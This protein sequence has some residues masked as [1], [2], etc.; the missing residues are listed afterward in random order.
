M[1]RIKQDQRTIRSSQ[2]IYR[3]LAQLMREKSFAKISVTNIVE[4]AQ[5]G[6]TTFYRIFD[7]I[8]DV[9]NLRMWLEVNGRRY[10]DGNSKTMIFKP[11]EIVSFLS[12]YMTLEPGDVVS[13][14]TP[15]GVGLGQNPPVYLNV[16][17]KI[18]LG[19]DCL[20]FQTQTVVG[21]E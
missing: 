17:D 20:G 18:T 9:L 11:A 7:E 4:K 8:E 1:Y 19:I 10:Q 14:G 3:A 13:T 21:I 12:Q 2:L 15:P 5:V 16:G 6:R